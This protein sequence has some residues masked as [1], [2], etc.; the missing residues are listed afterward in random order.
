MKIL[1]IINDLRI[2]GA[3]KLVVEMLPLLRERGHEVELLLFDGKDTPFK[4]ELERTGITIH[5]LCSSIS[6]YNPLH[7]LLLRK[8][9]NGYDI[10]HAHNFTPQYYV[11]FAKLLFGKKVKLITTEHSTHN[12]RREIAL[13]RPIDKLVYKQY[14][15]IACITQMVEKNLRNYIFTRKHIFTVN[16]GINTQVF[17]NAVQQDKAALLGIS[18]D[19]KVIMQVAGFRE[20]KD[21]DCVIRSLLHLP[22]NVVAVFVGDGVRRAKC[23]EL[24][25]ELGVSER[26]YFLGI[27]SDIPTLL[28]SADIVVM[29]SHWEGFGLAAVEGMA[30]GKPTIASNVE[31]LREV[32]DGAGLLFENN[33]EK[34]LAK[35]IT[36]LLN[37]PDYYDRIAERCAQRTLDYDIQKMIDE[38][39]REYIRILN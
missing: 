4:Q 21:Q 36:D 22:K 17:Q 13:F 30:A 16:N 9:I 2:G 18:D 33:N 38:Y 26:V 5:T 10:I 27:R 6:V 29:S 23:E 31:G 39:E 20:A 37:D 19:A 25:K 8:Y 35:V 3:E 28:K 34:E 7:A 11:A 24:S 32:V 1:H 15:S 12:R 14:D